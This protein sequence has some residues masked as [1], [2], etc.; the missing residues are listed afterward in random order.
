MTMTAIRHG[1]RPAPLEITLD[2]EPIRVTFQSTM[3]DPEVRALIAA[4][5][6]KLDA[7]GF[8]EHGWR[9]A[10]QV[11]DVAWQL[12]QDLGLD[13]HL[14]E[15]AKIAGLLHDIGNA[16]SRRNHAATGALL[17]HAVLSRLGMPPDDIA[18]IIGAI[19]SHGDDHGSPGIATDPA[20]AALILADKADVHRSR[21]R[22]D[23]VTHFDVHDRVGFAVLSSSVF[24]STATNAITLEILLD[25]RLA[26]PR[27]FQDL[28]RRQLAMCRQA[29]ALLSRTFDVVIAEVATG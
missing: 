20:S 2:F 12:L 11:A 19:G 16:I 8:N 21:V 27:E 18:V 26:S 14:T 28:F 5:D 6:G 9:H 22:T 13:S 29:A 3:N 24:A 7:L 23:D 25:Y 1:S 17:A 4:A 15:L 10:N